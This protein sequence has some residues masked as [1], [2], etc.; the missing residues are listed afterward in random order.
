VGNFINLF[1]TNFMVIT[2]MI[3]SSP[4]KIQPIRKPLEELLSLSSADVRAYLERLPI[5]ERK[6]LS[7]ELYKALLQ[8]DMQNNRESGSRP[9]PIG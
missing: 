2:G 1:S 5:L 7:T 4:K 3:M 9:G 6:Q 8:R